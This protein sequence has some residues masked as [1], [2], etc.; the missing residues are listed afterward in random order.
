M[1]DS[2][3][4]LGTR[5]DRWEAAR[6]LQHSNL[7]EMV[8]P[9]YSWEL[10][11][12]LIRSTIDPE[13]PLDLQAALYMQ[14]ASCGI[15]SHKHELVRTSAE[16][17]L[18]KATEAGEESL[19]HRARTM[20]GNEALMIG[21]L[22]RAISFYEEALRQRELF[23]SPAKLAGTLSNLAV[24]FSLRADFEEALETFAEAV[25]VWEMTEPV[26]SMSTAWYL[27]ARLHTELQMRDDA[28]QAIQRC[29]E[30]CS[31]IGFRKNANMC[32]VLEAD[33]ASQEGEHEEATRLAREAMK[34]L[35]QTPNVSPEAH[36]S[37]VRVLRC[38][39]HIEESGRMLE[40][41][42]SQKIDDSYSVAR[43]NLEKARHLM[44]AGDEEAATGHVQKANELFLA[45]GAPKRVL[46]GL[47]SL[48]YKQVSRP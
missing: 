6:Q 9:S 20:L 5:K 17:A 15:Y 40:E 36:E 35:E 43:L 4:A 22:K 24:A 21:E 47:P 44:I 14:L 31:K 39:G 42:M 37:I 8:G 3:E 29:R 45:L 18:R 32:I 2:L 16:I 1:Q 34:A 11:E 7:T 28:R 26:I 41:M 23:S 19:A 25:S 38:A 10:A 13:M 12:S 46:K 33:L 27:K 30:V 48:D